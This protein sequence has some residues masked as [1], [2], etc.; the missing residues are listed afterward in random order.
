M[1]IDLSDEFLADVQ[2]PAHPCPPARCTTEEWLAEA[3][4]LEHFD[5]AFAEALV[6]SANRQLH[7]AVGRFSK[8]EPIDRLLATGCTLAE[9][10][11]QLGLSPVQVAAQLVR[12]PLD[13]PAY[14]AAE[15]QLR[16]D[17]R[18][19]YAECARRAGLIGRYEDPQA[20]VKRVAVR[21]GLERDGRQVD[22][23]EIATVVR[24]RDDEGMSWREIGRQLG[25]NHAT[26]HRLYARKDAA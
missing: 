26:A 19:G 24:M 6:E 11:E 16:A 2:I 10:A 15:E 23:N 4:T 13:A 25:I 9:C 21:L 3:A 1:S 5:G 20:F 14:L 17:H 8:Q 7:T 22:P 12:S 18:A